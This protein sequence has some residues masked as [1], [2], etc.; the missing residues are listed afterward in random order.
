MSLKT[1]RA[2]RKATGVNASEARRIV[3]RAR[4]EYAGVVT[5]VV[6]RETGLP[7]T[8]YEAE[9]AAL[10]VESGPYAT[11]CEVHN[12]CTHH[13]SAKLARRHLASPTV[14]CEECREIAEEE[15]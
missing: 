13:G 9:A 10:D 7:V 14:W 12:S 5:S 2:I 4:S 8:V 15:A 6:S 1:R 3:A 11:V